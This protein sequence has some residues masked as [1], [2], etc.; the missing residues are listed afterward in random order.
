M[1][2]WSRLP[3][4]SADHYNL[5]TYFFISAIVYLLSGHGHE[6]TLLALKGKYEIHR[7][8]MLVSERAENL[9]ED[10]SELM[11]QELIDK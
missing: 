1:L 4:A 6:T 3:P 2:R 9:Q 8:K 5:W 10:L 7:Q 11:C